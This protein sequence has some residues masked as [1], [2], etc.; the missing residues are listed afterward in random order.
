VK[1]MRQNNNFYRIRKSPKKGKSSNV[2]LLKKYHNFGETI[3]YLTINELKQLFDC[4]DNYHHKLMFQVIYELGCRV[5]EFVRIQIK[6]LN[7]SRSTVFFPAENTKTKYPRTSYL[8]KGL[9]NEI[10]SILKQKQIIS[11]REG[12]VRKSTAYLF[13]PGKRWNQQYTENRIRQ[14]FQYYAKQAKLQNVYGNDVA[15]RNLKMF[16][17][18]S[19]RHSHVMHYTIDYKLPLPIVQKQVGHRSLKTTSIYLK[20]S[21]EKIAEAYEKAAS[22]S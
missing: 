22:K 17:V 6:H 11:K 21:T 16:T 2:K 7:F 3:R 18:H 9:M 5:G 13:H 20:P 14:I 8:P 19:L 10:K 12:H 4:I 15:G 1:K